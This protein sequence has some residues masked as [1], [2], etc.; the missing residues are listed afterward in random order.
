VLLLVEQFTISINLVSVFQLRYMVFLPSKAVNNTVM[1]T[2]IRAM[3][4]L[5]NMQVLKLLTLRWCS[6]SGC[7][8]E[9]VADV[10]ASK[11]C[12]YLINGCPQPI[13]TQLTQ[14][15]KLEIIDAPLTLML[16]MGRWPWLLSLLAIKAA[17]MPVIHI[18][19]Q[20]TGELPYL[21]HHKSLT[22]RWRSC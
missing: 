8:R 11:G 13:R 9:H 16:R 15:A 4:C 7:R 22:L 17:N 12:Q 19:N 1:H 14:D 20:V 5:R 3:P 2:K 10:F 6:F 21:Q 18:N